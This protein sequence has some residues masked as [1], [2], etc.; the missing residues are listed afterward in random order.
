MWVSVTIPLVENLHRQGHTA[1][2]SYAYSGRSVYTVG[3]VYMDDVDLITVGFHS[4]EP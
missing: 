2:L 1:Q 4:E 3:N